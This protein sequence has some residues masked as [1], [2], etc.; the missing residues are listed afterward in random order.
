MIPT[1]SWRHWIWSCFSNRRAAAGRRVRSRRSPWRDS[2]PAMI[3]RLEQRIVLAAPHPF[4]LSTLLPANG[5]TGAT[6]FALNGVAENDHSG[7]SVQS[8]GDVNG[9]GLDDLLIG[10]QYA[11]P[12]SRDRAGATYLVFGTVEGTQASLNLA[13]LNGTNG[14]VL[15]GINVGDRSG[16][17]VSGAGDVNGDGFDDLL[18]GALYAS[19]FSGFGQSYVVFGGLANLDALDDVTSGGGTANDG[20]INLADLNGTNGFVLNGLVAFDYSGFAVSGAGDV[21]GDGF[22]DLLISAHRA[23]PNGYDSGQSYVVFGGL[24]N[25]DALDDVTGS[26]GTANDGRI[27]LADLNGTNGFVLNG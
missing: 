25:L 7:G 22:D 11:D 2:T 26:G 8:A 15:N 12:D 17:A 9:D 13:D 23:D 20:R 21:N 4:Q 18:I 14:F 10:A 24:A 6:G 3:E 1:F 27:N 19:N 5:G 16:C